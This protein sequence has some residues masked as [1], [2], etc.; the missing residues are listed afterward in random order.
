MI[1]FE[2]VA[3]HTLGCLLI[4][5]NELTE[6]HKPNSSR[7]YSLFQAIERTKII[8]LKIYK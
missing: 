2:D 8:N 5:A 4:H 1:N 6:I 3:I 7:F